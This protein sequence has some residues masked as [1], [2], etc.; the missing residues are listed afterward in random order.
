MGMGDDSGDPE[1]EAPVHTSETDVPTTG[2]DAAGEAASGETDAVEATDGASEADAGS[3]PD[4]TTG[5]DAPPAPTPARP[6]PLGAVLREGIADAVLVRSRPAFGERVLSEGVA[7][8]A[9]AAES[10]TLT[11]IDRVAGEPGYDL[12]QSVLGIPDAVQAGGDAE[13]EAERLADLVRPGGRLVLA[14]W[15]RGALEPLPALVFGALAPVQTGDT[16]VEDPA[17]ITPV[18]EGADTAGSFAFALGELGLAQVRAEAV[19]RRFEL[20]G[21][22]GAD[23]AWALAERTGMV[24]AFEVAADDLPQARSRFDAALADQGIRS[25]DLTMLIAAARRPA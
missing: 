12:V 20:D 24:A 19:P 11:R 2:A 22:S 21:A 23:A 1:G 4:E 13:E 10:L 7:E 18:I 3:A 16:P 6:H 15:A 25:L 8:A 17:D 14:V 9:E 5:A